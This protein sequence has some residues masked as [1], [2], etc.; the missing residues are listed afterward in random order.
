MM[1]PQSD[2]VIKNMKKDDLKLAIKWAENEGWNPGVY[3]EDSFYPTDPDGFFMGYLR[4]EPVSCISAVAYDNKFGFLGLYI[5]KPEFRGKGMGIKIWEKGLEYLQDRNIGLDGVSAQQQN[6]KNYGF[7]PSHK[8]IRFSGIVEGIHDISENLCALKS[9]PVKKLV[10]Y[11]T[12]IFSTN[13]SKFLVKWINQNQSRALGFLSG[14]DLSGYGVIRPCG[15]GFKIGPLFAENEQ[16]A[17]EL[18]KG[19]TQN[20]IGKTV[21]LDVPE[22]NSSALAFATRNNM[23]KVFETVRMY[24]KYIPNLPLEIFGITTLELG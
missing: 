4:Q 19:L 15:V 3:D 14:N 18:F 24:N 16:I 5:V 6:Y 23:K 8:N 17:Q 22:P 12:K 10:K 20:L 21:F 1:N 13:R 2:Y 11:D 9:F 7:K